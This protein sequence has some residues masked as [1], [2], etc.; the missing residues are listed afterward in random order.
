MSE[1]RLRQSGPVVWL[2][3]AGACLASLGLSA[4]SSSGQSSSSS[5]TS[6][7][8][9][10]QGAG[11]ASSAAPVSST[12]AEAQAVV[13]NATNFSKLSYP[14]KPTPYKP[15]V[16]SVAIISDGQQGAVDALM[17]AQAEEAAKAMGWKPS[18][19]MDGKLDPTVQASLIQQAV[20]QGYDAILDIAV[21]P[22]TAS[23]AI[24]AAAAKNIPVVCVDCVPSG[25]AADKHVIYVT[26]SQ[27]EAG[28]NMA[29]LITTRLDG[30]GT[31]VGFTDNEYTSVVARMDGLK[32]GLAKYCPNCVYETVPITVSEIGEPGPPTWSSFLSTHGSGSANWAAFGYDAVAEPAGV[33]E[34]Q[35]GRT[36]IPISGFNGEMPMIDLMDSNKAPAIAATVAFPDPYYAWAGLDELGRVLNHLP[37]WDAAALPSGLVV[38]SNVSQ[39]SGGYLNTPFNLESYFSSVWEK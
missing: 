13:D 27:T 12:L 20:T 36:D 18:P 19:I 23:S 25:A 31:V 37:T 28:E 14:P 5:P 7:S 24:D 6:S 33:T 34:A 3:V 4:C 38:K 8:G 16:H 21:D 39:V 35:D 26:S 22:A 30:K 1:T 15:G 2:V 10:S 32:T 29:A 17:A 9:G 11:T